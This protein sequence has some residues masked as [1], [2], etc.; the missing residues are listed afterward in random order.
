[1]IGETEKL[2]ENVTEANQE[3]RALAQTRQTNDRDD[4]EKHAASA[5]IHRTDRNVL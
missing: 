3:L 2:G 1:M 5:K 4:G